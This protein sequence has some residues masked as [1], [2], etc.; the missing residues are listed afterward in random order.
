MINGACDRYR[1]VCFRPPTSCSHLARVHPLDLL[2]IARLDL[3][4]HR[5]HSGGIRFN[6]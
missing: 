5:D 4:A 6:K 2:A 1:N 3:V